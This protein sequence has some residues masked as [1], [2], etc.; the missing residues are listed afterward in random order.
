MCTMRR[1]EQESAWCSPCPPPRA[2][3]SRPTRLPPGRR[4]LRVTVGALRAAELEVVKLRK[5]GAEISIAIAGARDA[6]PAAAGYR[7]AGLA[8]PAWRAVVLHD[9]ADHV[10]P[11]QRDARVL[12]PAHAHLVHEREQP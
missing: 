10:M 7:T 6:R 9:H 5:L 4:T 3:T 2:A 11:R 1:A 8:A 12:A